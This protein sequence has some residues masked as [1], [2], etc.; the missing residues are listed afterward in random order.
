MK[1]KKTLLILLLFIVVAPYVYGQNSITITATKDANINSRP[2]LSNNNYG[3]TIRL[4]ARSMNTNNTTRGLLDFDLSS[5]PQNICITDARLTLTPYNINHPTTF[6]GY[7]GLIVRQINQPWNETTVTWNNK[8]TYGTQNAFSTI[9]GSTVSF[10]QN[11]NVT[12]MISDKYY[13]NGIGNYGMDIQLVTEQP[14]RSAVFCSAE[15]A[16]INARP[17]LVITYTLTPQYTIAKVQNNSSLCISTPVVALTIVGNNNTCSTI[18]NSYWTFENNPTQIGTGTL[19]TNVVN[20]G[21]Y[22]YHAVYASGYTYKISYEVEPCC[23][24]LN[25]YITLNSG[26]YTQG[27]NFGVMTNT[28]ATNVAG[29]FLQILNNNPTV[30]DIYVNGSIA[31]AGYISPSIGSSQ[32]IILD[33]YNFYINGNCNSEGVNTQIRFITCDVILKNCTFQTSDCDCMWEGIEIWDD[34]VIPSEVGEY[35]FIDCE[36]RDAEKAL[37][38]NTYGNLEVTSISTKYINNRESII[39]N[40]EP[41]TFTYYNLVFRENTFDSD[42]NTMLLPYEGSISYK[43]INY[44]SGTS[45]STSLLGQVPPWSFPSKIISNKFLNAEYGIYSED[46]HTNNPLNVAEP[47]GLKAEISNNTF[48]RTYRAGIFCKPS[49]SKPSQLVLTENSFL[50]KVAP[51][52]YGTFTQYG[53]YSDHDLDINY[54]EYK[55]DYELSNTNPYIG[56]F[57]ET[58]YDIN[59]KVGTLKINNSRFYALKTAISVMPTGFVDGGN[60]PI[61]SDLIEIRSN[62]IEDNEVGIEFRENQS[63]QNFL[64]SSLGS[65]SFS[66]NETQ[67]EIHCN[68]FVRGYSWK[69]NDIF[70]A[71]YI[72]PDCSIGNI[73]DCDNGP[74]GN[75]VIGP[76]N[77]M[78]SIWNLGN[79]I[80]KYNMYDNENL[81]NYPYLF[82]DFINCG[83]EAKDETCRGKSGILK[84]APVNTLT[85]INTTTPQSIIEL[86]PNPSSSGIFNLKTIGFNS[87]KSVKVMNISGQLL[88]ELK[89][90]GTQSQIDL[91]SYSKGLYFIKVTDGNYEKIEKII[92]E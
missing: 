61:A 79:N 74:A 83:I 25:N 10:Y 37:K 56:V 80:L 32:P 14:T 59:S 35:E 31:I 71:I 18:T 48:D 46:I 57:H 88:I 53:V 24:E 84:K 29:D 39:V 23:V 73:G 52:Y 92:F 66:N 76:D 11:I 5:L 68:E 54:D 78:Q 19:L 86:Y 44:E 47:L 75:E 6:I 60:N 7:N 9:A 72:N 49:A 63:Y 65:A 70:S 42:K 28:G 33:G 55:G 90:N 3:N 40:K 87:T 26:V 89:L 12:N 30:K 13:S 41:F 27:F 8:P 21:T 85:N 51:S 43:H 16:N 77:T 17:K 22:Y 15:H 1:T 2:N 64:S 4:S 58:A 91:S 45:A 50:F 81:I 20:P 67:N 62:H 82:V 69:E 38:L 34:G 36:I